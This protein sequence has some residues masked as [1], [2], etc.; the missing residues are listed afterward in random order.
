[1]KF[2]D[3]SKHRSG[4][5]N[6][7]FFS[8]SVVT[9]WSPDLRLVSLFQF[10]FLHWCSEWKQIKT[11]QSSTSCQLTLVFETSPLEARSSVCIELFKVFNL[12]Q[13]NLIEDA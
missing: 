3:E 8:A 4:D 11:I 5:L 9:I 7:Q 1:M 6:F 10:W 2:R 12:K 13:S